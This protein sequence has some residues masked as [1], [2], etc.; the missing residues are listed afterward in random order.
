[1][2]LFLPPIFLAPFAD[3][4]CQRY[5]R[6][7]IIWIGSVI[8]IAGAL[9]NGLCTSIGQYMGGMSESVERRLLM[10]ARTLIGLGGTLTKVA[11]PALLHELAHPR[12]R[13]TLGVMYYGL[14]RLYKPPSFNSYPGFYYTGSLTSA[15][16]CSQLDHAVARYMS[17]WQSLV[18][19]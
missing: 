16:M 4:A 19:T 12:L 17:N 11:A 1:M 3:M 18:C 6:R 10:T 2:T 13:G 7:W 5:G 9:W 8:I 15:C 14:S